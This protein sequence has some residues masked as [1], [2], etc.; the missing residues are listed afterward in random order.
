M[1]R[2]AP[3]SIH[4]RRD[5]A[6][7]IQP[8]AVAAPARTSPPRIAG[9]NAECAL[10]GTKAPASARGA[11]SPLRHAR[12]SRASLACRA[13]TYPPRPSAS[14]AG[15]ARGATSGTGRRVRMW[16]SVLR[17]HAI[18]SRHAPT[19]WARSRAPL[20]LQHTE[21][22]A[23]LAAWRSRRAPWIMGGATASRSAAKGRSTPGGRAWPPVTRRRT[24]HAAR[25]PGRALNPAT[26]E[27][28]CP[29]VRI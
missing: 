8:P 16:T 20:A 10:L 12:S 19:P 2:R 1:G 15:H 9:S 24:L 27:T 21:V 29:D 7:E 28:D 23:S 5:H 25:A 22:T 17:P 13:P 6:G 26:S 4:V 18:R 3:R 14:A 11:A